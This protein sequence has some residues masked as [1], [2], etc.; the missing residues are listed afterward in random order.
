MAAL[1]PIDPPDDNPGEDRGEDE[2]RVDVCD[3]YYLELY[4][5]TLEEIAHSKEYPLPCPDDQPADNAT[6]MV[7]VRCPRCLAREVLSS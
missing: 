4:R 1:H 3:R 2:V 5:R 6:R 7:D